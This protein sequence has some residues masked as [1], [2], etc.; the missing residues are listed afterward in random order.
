MFDLE[1]KYIKEILSRKNKLI[2]P[3]I[4]NVA[5]A[6]LVFSLTEPKMNFGLLDRML[7]IMEY[8][9]LN[10][11]ILL[12]KRDLLTSLQMKELLPK[13]EYYKK[14]GYQIMYNNE[15]K[16]EEELQKYLMSNEKY[17]LT[18]QSG[19]GKSTFLNTIGNNLDLKTQEI[20][21]ALGRGKHTTRETTFYK[22]KTN[23]L[24][25]TPGFSALDLNLS[26]EEIRD[27]FI[28]FKQLSG[29]CKFSSCYHINEPNCAVKN[30]LEQ[31]N[32]FK[33]RYNNYKKLMEDK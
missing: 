23:Y 22:V 27:N 29:N 32:I 2:R 24:V 25:D 16:T 11:I 21:K 12:T 7:M 33:E 9:K 30:E 18:G 14:I 19:V 28:D 31:G 6:I 5:N 10:S 8:N 1:N 4:C 3:K 17:V 13:L 15:V 20:S 26:R